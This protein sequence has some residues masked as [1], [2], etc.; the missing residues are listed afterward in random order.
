MEKEKL[1]RPSSKDV[2][3][4]RMEGGFSLSRFDNDDTWSFN[5][6][7]DRVNQLLDGGEHFNDLH[8]QSRQ[9][10][11]DDNNDGE[12]QLPNESILKYIEEKGFQRP[13]VN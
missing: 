9:V 3:N 12:V 8:R 2:M 1:S 13:T 11:I 4:I 6:N 5:S 10:I 7:C